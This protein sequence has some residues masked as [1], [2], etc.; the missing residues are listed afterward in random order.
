MWNKIVDI[1]S[2][3]KRKKIRQEKAIS[4]E[5]EKINKVIADFLVEW[6]SD[7]KQNPYSDKVNTPKTILDTVH[8]MYTFENGLVFTLDNEGVLIFTKDGIEY[9]YRLGYLYKRIYIE[10]ANSTIK[11]QCNRLP[12][13]KPVPENYKNNKHPKWELY[14]K[15]VETIEK[16]EEDL[17]AC[18]TKGKRRDLENELNAA[19][20]RMNTIKQKYAF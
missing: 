18:R 16:R 4:E 9:K 19:K 17:K 3:S 12:K 7:F 13:A 11:N 20:I 14:S 5:Q 10:Y 15:L 1:F 8:Y 2:S 6:V